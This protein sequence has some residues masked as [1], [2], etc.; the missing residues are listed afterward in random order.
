MAEILKARGESG[1]WALGAINFRSVVA[2]L[3]Q[4]F[5]APMVGTGPA[6]RQ[7]SRRSSLEMVRWMILP[8]S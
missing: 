4:W 2:L 5:H 1:I 6:A 3:K 7:S 8:A